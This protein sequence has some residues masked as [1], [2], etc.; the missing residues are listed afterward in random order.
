[1][2]LFTDTRDTIHIVSDSGRICFPNSTLDD[3]DVVHNGISAGHNIAE[4]RD[5]YVDSGDDGD[6][7]IA[8]GDHDIGQR[9][10]PFPIL[11]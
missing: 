11:E 9:H 8:D 7:R 3:T 5:I 1:M 4:A 6:D 2:Q 10:P